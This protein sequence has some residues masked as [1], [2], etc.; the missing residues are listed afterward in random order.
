MGGS[1]LAGAV[2]EACEGSGAA[3]VMLDSSVTDESG[4]YRIGNLGPGVSYTTRVKL[5]GRVTSAHPA[6]V[7]VCIPLQG[8]G[9][10]VTHS[11]R[12][13]VEHLPCVVLEGLPSL[14]AQVTHPKGSSC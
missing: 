6:S 4:H 8:I 9:T 7:K 12:T 1:P 13:H 3:A 2:V 10:P 11:H 14:A 5:D